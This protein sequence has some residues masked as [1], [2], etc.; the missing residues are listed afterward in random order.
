MGFKSSGLNV[1]VKHQHAEYQLASNGS[2][3]R[4]GPFWTVYRAYRLPEIYAAQHNL[5]LALAVCDINSALFMATI[6]TR[7]GTLKIVE[8]ICI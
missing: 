7:Q 2:F 1:H 5:G 6:P 8:Y 4:D 3:T